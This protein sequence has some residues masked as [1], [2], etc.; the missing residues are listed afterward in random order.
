MSKCI[1]YQ[2]YY[3]YVTLI[4][5]ISK[6]NTLQHEAV[7]FS[8]PITVDISLALSY[9]ISKMIMKS[10]VFKSAVSFAENSLR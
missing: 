7:L 8:L 10:K 1:F 4:A 9:K 6:K 3:Y 5:Y 2:D